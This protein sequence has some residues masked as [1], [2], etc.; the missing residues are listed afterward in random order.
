MS[1]GPDNLRPSYQQ[2]LEHL[3]HARYLT[4]NHVW[5]LC[6]TQGEVKY[7][8]EHLRELKGWGYLLTR[9]RLVNE[10]AIYYLAVRGKH[11]LVKQGYCELDE[12]HKTAGVAGGTEVPM[13]HDLT[14]SSLYVAFVLQC[15]KY[16]WTYLW[17]NTRQ[18]KLELGKVRI[19]P[20]AWLSITG[21]KGSVEAYVEFTDVLPS[22]GEMNA[23]LKGY[24]ALYAIVGMTPVLWFTTTPNKLE[25]LARMAKGFEYRDYLFFGLV[26]DKS[27]F[28][29]GKVWRLGDEAEVN[30]IEKPVETV[31]YEAKGGE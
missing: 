5:Q 1:R 30:F 14:L 24:R 3:Y 31:L 17:K 18:L 9:N 4:V 13:P 29:T 26:E 12:I 6:F 23:K 19:E 22:T 21:K 27:Q 15:R 10:P 20:D 16:G 11:W 28:L 8:G 25:R 2:I 7:A